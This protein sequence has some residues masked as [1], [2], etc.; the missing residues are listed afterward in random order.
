MVSGH[1]ASE[2]LAMIGWMIDDAWPFWWILWLL[3]PL[4]LIAIATSW[5]GAT[6]SERR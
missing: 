4:L 1:G 2:G 5:G 3:V 6:L